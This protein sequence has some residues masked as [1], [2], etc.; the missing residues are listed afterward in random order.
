MEKHPEWAEASRSN[1]IGARLGV[2]K[3]MITSGG[4][5]EQ[6]RNTF[7]KIRKEILSMPLPDEARK[8]IKIEYFVL[9]LGVVPYRTLAK[10]YYAIIN[11]NLRM[12]RNEWVTRQPIAE[13]CGVT[14]EIK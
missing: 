14:Q 9:Q 6:N 3:A 5:T 4:G 13:G 11:D 12:K 7:Q 10:L 8:T 1:Q 2:L